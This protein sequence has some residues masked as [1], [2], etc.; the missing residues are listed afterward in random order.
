MQKL[1]LDQ[2]VDTWQTSLTLAELSSLPIPVLSIIAYI[3]YGIRYC[4]TRRHTQ[5]FALT[6]EHTCCIACQVQTW[7]SQFQGQLP[8][9][10]E[11]SHTRHK[12]PLEHVASSTF[13]SLIHVT[14]LRCTAC[15]PRV[16]PSILLPACRSNLAVTHSSPPKQQRRAVTTT[17]R[18][19]FMSSKDSCHHDRVCA[20][21]SR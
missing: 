6:A 13:A 3:F 1:Q 4:D 7:H 8:G 16:L 11:H 19:S 15:L 17:A 12:T 21:V 9:P 20:F 18:N 5:R 2:H 14:F 10:H